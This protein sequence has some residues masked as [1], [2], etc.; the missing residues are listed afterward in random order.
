[1]S[2]GIVD[3]A[4]PASSHLEGFEDADFSLHQS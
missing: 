4:M 1:M 2:A 3:S